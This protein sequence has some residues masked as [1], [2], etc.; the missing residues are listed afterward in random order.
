MEN[1]NLQKDWSL[2]KWISK[3]TKEKEIN[4]NGLCQKFARKGTWTLFL[5]LAIGFPISDNCGAL[6]IS[7]AV[8]IKSRQNNLVCF[9]LENKEA[10]SFL[11]LLGT[12]EDLAKLKDFV[13]ELPLREEFSLILFL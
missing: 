12:N 9:V 5:M 2:T 3:L 8:W 4:I 6:T 1:E 13:L 10:G 7:P 11:P